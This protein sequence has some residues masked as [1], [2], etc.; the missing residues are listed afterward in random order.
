MAKAELAGGINFGSG[1]DA[2]FDE[3]DRF[4]FQRVQ[5]AVHREADHILDADRGFLP[6]AVNASAA[7]SA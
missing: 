7:A 2:F 6:I 1:A 4:D 3:A 5:Q